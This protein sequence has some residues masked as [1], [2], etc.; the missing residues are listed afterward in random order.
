[1][2]SAKVAFGPP[3]GAMVPI[4]GEDVSGASTVQVTVSPDA[5]TLGWWMSVIG[6]ST[7]STA[8]G[9]QV[10]LRPNGIT[11]NQE[12]SRIQTDSTASAVSANLN[13]SYLSFGFVGVVSSSL[14]AT[15]FLEARTGYGIGRA[16][17]GTNVEIRAA[18]TQYRWT[19]LGSWKDNT[20]AVT[21][22]DFVPL[23]TALAAGEF[24][25]GSRIEVYEVRSL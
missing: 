9:L 1:M 25:V 16:F 13:G 18:G 20:T 6:K 21:R 19:V 10:N 22:L 17:S 15:A 14:H 3:I 5:K 23:T 2:A 7:A 24:D 8:A 4:Y 11:A 12:S